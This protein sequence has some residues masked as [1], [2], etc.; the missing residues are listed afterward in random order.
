MLY[1]IWFFFFS[2]IV[3]LCM[4]SWHFLTFLTYLGTFQYGEKK[5]IN[6][7]IWKIWYVSAFLFLFL[8]FFPPKN[9]SATFYFSAFYVRLIVLKRPAH[10]KKIS[11]IHSSKTLLQTQIKIFINTP[12]T[13]VW[14][15]C[16][17]VWQP[18]RLV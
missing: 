15:T 9:Q 5:F 16:F 1:S 18:N 7:F 3:T 12:M 2:S 4:P 10:P 14:F 17:L 6:S 13:T 8:F 11:D